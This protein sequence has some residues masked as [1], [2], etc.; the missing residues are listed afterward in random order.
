MKLCFSILASFSGPHPRHLRSSEL[1]DVINAWPLSKPDPSMPYDSDYA[2]CAREGDEVPRRVLDVIDS[3]SEET[4]FRILDAL[5]DK[6]YNTFWASI[7]DIQVNGILDREAT[8]EFLD[9]IGASFEDCKTMGTLG[10]PLSPGIVPD[11]PF[12]IE[13][14]GMIAS[15]RITPVLCRKEGDEWVPLRAPN[16]S[17]WK[18]IENIFRDA[19]VWEI[20]KRRAFTKTAITSDSNP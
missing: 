13:S 11:F 4:R 9:S 17:Q 8:F 7:C 1:R 3:S 10:G 18:R 5:S 20:H 12:G 2:Y 14:Q 16:E 19:D 15:I 6:G